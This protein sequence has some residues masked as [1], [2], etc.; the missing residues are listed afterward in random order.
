MHEFDTSYH[1]RAQYNRFHHFRWLRS[2]ASLPALT[3]TST[4][5]TTTTI[6]THNVSEDKI[7]ILS[8]RL[9]HVCI[10]Y[11]AT[12][13]APQVTKLDCSGTLLL[14]QQV[15]VEFFGGTKAVHKYNV[16]HCVSASTR[17]SVCLPVSFRI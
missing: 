12:D 3:A 2:A 9:R 8:T 14:E 17:I 7:V 11:A 6:A 1:E 5:P 15:V 13:S 10:E 16:A 4:T